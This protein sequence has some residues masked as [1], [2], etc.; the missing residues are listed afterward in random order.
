VPLVVVSEDVAE[1]LVK[2]DR[3][4]VFVDADARTI[5]VKKE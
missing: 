3:E 1:K 2:F 5:S 4:N